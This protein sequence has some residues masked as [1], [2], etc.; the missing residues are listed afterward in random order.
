MTG[1]Q[2]SRHWLLIAALSVCINARAQDERACEDAFKTAQS[3]C[4]TPSMTAGMNPQQQ[5]QGQMLMMQ[6][7]R[8]NMNV[9]ALGAAMAA[10]CENQAQMGKI[11]SALSAL[12]GGA[13]MATVAS[14]KKACGNGS[15]RMASRGSACGGLTVSGAAALAQ[16]AGMMAINS[17]VSEQCAK[18]AGTMPAMD[19]TNPMFAKDNLMCLCQTDPKNPKC[20]G[21]PSYPGGVTTSGVNGGPMGPFGSGG[22]EDSGD[23][24]PIALGGGQPKTA[25]GSATVDGG[26]GMGLGGAGRSLQK[27]NEGQ[28]GAVA[29]TAKHVI[30][31][32]GSSA[33][34]GAGG[35]AGSGTRGSGGGRSAG[36]DF[37]M[38]NFLPRQA[39]RNV[40]GMKLP[41]VHGITGPL[42]PSIF[43]KVTHQYQNQK[44]NMIQD[45]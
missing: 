15:S 18:L 14:C 36:G 8:S 42:G 38:K 28:Y 41:S 3:A 34:G 37:N 13:C 19:C 27:I 21:N 7:Q 16:A 43:E 10:Q 20:Q 4:T 5:Q 39:S 45:R 26:G 9:Q 30:Q 31:G 23:G 33:G 29:K 2:I 44:R 17:K 32:T 11:M 25:S 24:L 35:G 12:K 1:I 22:D 6:A 40:A